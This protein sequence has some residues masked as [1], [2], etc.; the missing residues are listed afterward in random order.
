MRYRHAWVVTSN[1]LI[2]EAPRDIWMLIDDIIMQYWSPTFLARLVKILGM[3][4]MITIVVDTL[5][6]EYR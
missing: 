3:I 1:R 5:S 2:Y 4:A 6:K